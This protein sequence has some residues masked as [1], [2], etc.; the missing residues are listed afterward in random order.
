[1]K[2]KLRIFIVLFIAIYICVNI[3]SI[4]K[5]SDIKYAVEKY[6]TSG[7]FNR[8]KLCKINQWE[9]EFSDGNMCIISVH[10]IQKKAPHDLINYKMLL[11]KNKK[12]LWKL[13]KYYASP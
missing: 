1:M 4:K 5:T 7:I 12:G 2:K 13:K 8:H 3:Y 9:M 10:G 6:S 11:E